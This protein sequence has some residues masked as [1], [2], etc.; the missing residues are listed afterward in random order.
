MP[1]NIGTA[2]RALRLTLGALLLLLPFLAGLAGWLWWASLVAGIVFVA[3]AG[4]R[5]CPLYV[6][7]GL[8]TCRP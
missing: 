8:R 2:D 3:T 1:C 6:L 7:I 5:F 4:S